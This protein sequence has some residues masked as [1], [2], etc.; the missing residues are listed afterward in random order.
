M[1]PFVV[2]A[3]GML[4]FKEKP[5]FLTLI[6]MSLALT[7]VAVSTIHYG[8]FPLISVAL[9]FL[10][11]IYGAIKKFVQVESVLSI[12]AETIMM[13]PLCVAFL[14]LSPIR[15]D[16]ASSTSI[17]HLLFIGAGIVT[18]LPML[19]Y[20]FGVLKLPFVMLGFMQYICPTLSL[21]CGLFMGESITPDKLVSFSFIWAALAVYVV[22][23]LR[24]GK[25]T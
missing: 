13:T 16:L 6:A 3:L 24:A 17:D 12:A 21:F 14:L 10:F 15:G 8:R 9:S 5:T 20:S 2:F 23:V 22:S 7:G 18:A 4:V 25:K 19:L 11:A 1:T